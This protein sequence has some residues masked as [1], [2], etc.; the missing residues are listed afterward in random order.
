MFNVLFGCCSATRTSSSEAWNIAMFVESCTGI[1]A[2]RSFCLFYYDSLLFHDN[3]AQHLCRDLKPRNILVSRTSGVL[4]IA[5]FG[6]ARVVVPPICTLTREVVTLWYRAP[7]ILLGSNQYTLPIDIWSVGTIIA[8]MVTKRPMFQGHSEISQLF[9]IFNILGKPN[10]ATWPGVSGLPDWNN[11]LFPDFP[12][13]KLQPFVGNLDVEGY[14]LLEKLLVNDPAQRLTAT[15]AL[16]HPYFDSLLQ[17]VSGQ[18]GKIE[19]V[20]DTNTS[21]SAT[22]VM[23]TSTMTTAGT[24]TPATALT[25]T[26]IEDDSEHGRMHKKS[27]RFE[28]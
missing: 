28:P 26:D 1:V 8:E 11:G 25:A 5:D 2:C 14:D 15:A 7:E 17:Q 4:K 3:F 19:R 12:A 24:T 21:V 16:K 23:T 20:M 22:S 9:K 6:L 10:E 27:R 18:K 13:L